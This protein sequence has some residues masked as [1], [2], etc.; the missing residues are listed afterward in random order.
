MEVCPGRQRGN[1]M[2][3]DVCGKCV[4]VGE[5]AGVSWVVVVMSV[6]CVESCGYVALLWCS[7]RDCDIVMVE[8]IEKDVK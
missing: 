3:S 7:S 4:T 5:C 6:L 8:V 2:S 1:E